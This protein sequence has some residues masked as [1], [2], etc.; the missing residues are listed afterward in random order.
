M[1]LVNC[2]PFEANWNALIP[3][4]TCRFQIPGFA[5]ASATTNLA[6]ELIPLALAQKAIWGLHMSWRKK[7]GVS[8]VFFIGIMYV[9]PATPPSTPKNNLDFSSNHAL[10]NSG[11]VADAVRLYYSTR[12]FISTDT[13]YYFSIMALC[14][15]CET[16]CASLILC[17]PFAPK[18]LG[19][20][21]QTRAYAEL[22]NYMTLRTT[23]AST[24]NN[25]T[26]YRKTEEVPYGSKPKEIWVTMDT[27]V[28]RDG[29]AN[30]V[31]SNHPLNA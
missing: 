7:L 2:T 10:E 13:S 5:V 19:G 23:L 6:L 17:V 9:V 4:A 31:A 27:R 25:T 26:G 21:T 30:S 18:A 24:N 1:D 11:C 22:K 14:S 8:G 29:T 15:L 20:I 16:T 3:G 28:S 12:F